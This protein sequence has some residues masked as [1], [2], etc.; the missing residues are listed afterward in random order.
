MNLGQSF[1]QKKNPNETNYKHL[2]LTGAG[3]S[4]YRM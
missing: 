4:V 2:Y 3:K 1:M